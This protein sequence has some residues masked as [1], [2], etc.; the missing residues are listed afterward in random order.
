MNRLFDPPEKHLWQH[1][2]TGHVVMDEQRPGD[3]WTEVKV[4]DRP[5]YAD[6]EALADWSEGDN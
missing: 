5:C 4:S 6:L 3:D 1:N 2:R